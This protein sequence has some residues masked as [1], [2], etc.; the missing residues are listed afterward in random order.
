MVK[1]AFVLLDYNKEDKIILNILDE[2]KRD[3]C[4]R[5]YP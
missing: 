1:N 4:L 2:L 5:N 3:L